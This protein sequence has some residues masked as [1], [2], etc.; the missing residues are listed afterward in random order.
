MYVIH[1]VPWCCGKHAVLPLMAYDV[2][3]Y[4]ISL[5]NVVNNM[6]TML[7]VCNANVNAFQMEIRINYKC[8]ARVDNNSNK[9]YIHI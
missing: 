6:M 8:N 5:K 2:Y 1:T 3:Q 4:Y 7:F 9:N